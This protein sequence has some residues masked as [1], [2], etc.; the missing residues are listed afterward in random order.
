MDKMREIW[1]AH[2]EARDKAWREE[3][4]SFDTIDAFK[5]GVEW[6]A[7]RTV[8]RRRCGD[9]S[10]RCPGVKNWPLNEVEE[11]EDE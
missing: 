1:D 5:A 11:E 10:G 3:P 9:M 7:A 4:G 2:D 6:Q 8:P